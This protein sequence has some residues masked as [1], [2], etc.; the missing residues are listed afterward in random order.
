MNHTE[1]TGACSN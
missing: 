1:V